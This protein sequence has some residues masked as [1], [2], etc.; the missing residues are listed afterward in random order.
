METMFIWI[1]SNKCYIDEPLFQVR[2]AFSLFYIH[3]LLSPSFKSGTSLTQCCYRGSILGWKRS[4]YQFMSCQLLCQYF[5]LSHSEDI[6]S[7]GRHRRK[8]WDCGPLL[9]HNN[10][11]RDWFMWRKHW[12]VAAWKCNKGNCNQSIFSEDADYYRII[13]QSLLQLIRK[14][15]YHLLITCK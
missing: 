14:V 4:K 8:G 10:K 5:F 15:R 13:Y 6:F 7:G 3:K 1:S 2:R 11:Q 9:Q 12:S